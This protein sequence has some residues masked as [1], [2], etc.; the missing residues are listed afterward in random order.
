MN[1]A[2][3]FDQV[4]KTYRRGVRKGYPTLVGSFSQAAR[5]LMGREQNSQKPDWV[6]RNLSFEIQ[7][8]E[9]VGLIG[10]NGAGKTSA[11]RILTHINRPTEGLVRH[12]GRVGALIEVGA[13]VSPELTGREN[14]WLYG[15]MVGIP[16]AEIARR[17]DAIVDFS[18]LGRFV[19]LQVKYLSSGMLLRLGF[20]IASH[21]EPDIFAVDEALAVGDA[22]FQAKCVKRMGSL[23]E[24]GATILFVSH[25]LAAVEAL[26]PKTILLEKGQLIAFG[27]SSDV[28]EQYSRT[29]APSSRFIENSQKPGYPVRIVHASYRDTHGQEIIDTPSRGSLGIQLEFEADQD[30]REPNVIV[31]IS[32]GR[33]GALVEC[34]MLVDGRSPERTAKKWSCLLKIDDLPLRP[35]NFDVKVLVVSN[36]GYSPLMD[37]CDIGTLLVVGERGA[38]KQS[39]TNLVFGAPI[40]I[41]YEWVID[42]D[43][44]K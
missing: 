35:G 30:Y 44:V 4:G 13:G 7:Q 18:E 29:A 16:R 17:F 34:S 15:S 42:S 33:P 24:N 12:R 37:W 6:L 39:A 8:G 23:V 25:Q 20:S 31:S 1:W 19:D 28:I 36:D 22:S 40:A 10:H 26:C 38:G 41:D 21:L 11:L 14:I 43:L 2:V 5:A 27:P 9:S 3:Q 32:D